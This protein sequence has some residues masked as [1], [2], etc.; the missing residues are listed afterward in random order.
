MSKITVGIPVYN[1]S[2]YV[3]E[4]VNSVRYQSHKDIEILI[5]DDASTDDTYD[6]LKELKNKDDR[7]R[8]IQNKENKGIGFSRN[9]LIEEAT[10]DYFC[11]LSSD[12]RYKQHYLKS[13]LSVYEKGQFLFTA[14]DVIDGSGRKESTF[15]LPKLFTLP[16]LKVF[17]WNCALNN[18]MFC[19]YSTVFADI[20]FWR[21][22][23][24]DKSYHRCED[25]EHFLRIF[26]L[27]DTPLAIIS[28]PLVEYRI[29][30]EMGTAKIR[31]EIPA[32][33]KLTIIKIKNR[34]KIKR[35]ERKW[36]Y[37]Y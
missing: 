16:E 34:L 6:V 30:P 14:Y 12:D 37:T 18:T 31:N 5:L 23:K 27:N 32:I 20:E 36:K 9:R 29:F 3:I 21:K 26:I 25:L 10:G 2:K 4:A 22:H 24:F 15:N 11:F 8:L 13:C 33:N 1:D 17:T 19:N 35:E 7:I 28:K